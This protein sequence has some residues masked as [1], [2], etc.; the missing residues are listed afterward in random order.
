MPGVIT[1]PNLNLFFTTLETRFW[2]AFRTAE[3]WYERICTTYPVDS[4][5]W[6]SGWMDPSEPMREWLGDRVIHSFGLETYKVQMQIFEKT[7]AIDSFKLRWDKS[8]LYAPIAADFGRQAAKWPDYQV[9]DLLRNQRSQTGARQNGLD[10][11]SHW[12]TAHPV[13]YYDASK[14]T[15]S[16]DFRGGFAVNG[17]T[18]GGAFGVQAFNTL[19]QEFASRKAP[20]GEAIG[21][22]AD[23]SMG[24]SQLKASMVSVLQTQFFAPPTIGNLTGQVGPIDNPLKGWTDLF[25]NKDLQ[26]D[27]TSWYMLFVGGPIKPFS[28]LQNMAPDYVIRNRPDD[29]E[30]F[31]SHRHLHGSKAVGAPAWS[32]PW[33]SGISGP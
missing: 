32:F 19:W 10:G 3:A 23:L 16:N 21:I 27:P 2:T 18:V 25:I 1:P 5:D 13:D 12:N 11:L 26:G 9:R 7:G 15:F 17:V 6:A 4:E 30:E 24:P 8:G 31:S 14:G 20:N 33:L 28:W 29:P 22:E